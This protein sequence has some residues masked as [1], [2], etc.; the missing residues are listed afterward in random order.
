MNHATSKKLMLLIQD[1]PALGLVSGWA[2]FWT[3]IIKGLLDSAVNCV[4]VVSCMSYLKSIAS[5]AL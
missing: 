4:K 5:Y 3:N 1:E 2:G